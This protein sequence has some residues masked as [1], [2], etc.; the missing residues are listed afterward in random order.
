[1]ARSAKRLKMRARRRQRHGVIEGQDVLYE[2]PPARPGEPTRQILAKDAAME[3][4]QGREIR[5]AL[6][7][8]V[9]YSPSQSN[10]LDSS[11]RL[12]TRFS[13]EAQRYTNVERNAAK[14]AMDFNGMS[15]DALTFAESS[16]FPGFPTLVLLGQLAEYR[17]MAEALADECVRL[18]GEVISEGS[19]TTAQMVDMLNAEVRRIGLAEICRQLVAHDQLFGG[20]HAFIKLKNDEDVRELPLMLKPF[21]IPK[22]AFE[23]LRVVE[24]YWVTPNFYNSIDPTRPDFYKPSSWWMLGVE[25]HATRLITI[26]SRPVGDMLKAA[27]SFRG[28]SLTQIAMPYVDNWLRTR[29][30]VSDTVKQFSVSGILTDLQQYLLPGAATDLNHRIELY[31]RYRDNRN[32]MI[33]DKA[34]EEFFQFNTPLG[35]LEAL[36]AQAQEQMS[37]VSQ[38]PLVKLLGITPT[39]LNASSEG[40][41]R[42]WYD[43]VKG[44][45]TN[46]LTPFVMYVLQ[47]IQLSLFGRI[48]PAVSWKWTELM[49]LTPL[50]RADVQLRNAQ[51]DAHYLEHAVVSP[52]DVIER[53]KGDPNSLYAGSL[54]AATLDE[55][56]DDDLPAIVERVEQSLAEL[57]D[58][59][60]V[61]GQQNASAIAGQTA[62]ETAADPASQARSGALSTGTE[63][64]A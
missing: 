61:Y 32:T 7:M 22:G 50:E 49:E 42:V 28:I 51:T 5:R 47:V 21:S 3:T 6:G 31:N 57:D 58:P 26:V 48:D 36:Q 37:A 27:Y 38:T 20:A 2:L 10:L 18:F 52:D 53:L 19:A 11:L 4:A 13:V 15:M 24:P 39:G 45:Q 43:R 1:M 16:G 63:P 62:S 12:A 30:S 55:I 8:A 56:P 54:D 40:E 29:Q 60:K 41:I 17:N 14:H 44:Y 23:G 64:L 34:T 35:G 9:D 46:A 33:L 25:T 59:D